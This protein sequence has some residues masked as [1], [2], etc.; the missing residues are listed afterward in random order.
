[1]KRLAMFV[2]VVA[3]VL[4]A[5]TVLS[6]AMAQPPAQPANHEHLEELNWLIGR[7]IHRG[8]T[9][10]GQ[11]LVVRRSHDWALDGNYVTGVTKIRVDNRLVLVRRHMVGWDSEE[12]YIRSWVF[13]SN[14]DFARGVWQKTVGN[15]RIG[16]MS[17][18]RPDAKHMTATVTYTL[19][20][21]DT[22]IYRSDL[23]ID[24]QPQPVIIWTFKRVASGN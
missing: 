10:G 8:R 16:K 20:D 7:W 13:S 2:A 22:F 12:K 11:P 18:L 1:M 24:G 9:P 4:P 17:G 3:V 19:V 23:Q 14:G 15:K 21:D 6:R 5:V